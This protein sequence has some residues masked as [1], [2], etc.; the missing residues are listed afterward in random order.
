M[1]S[2]GELL[3]VAESVGARQRHSVEPRRLPCVIGV[4]SGLGGNAFE[5][6]LSRRDPR[7]YAR[8]PVAAHLVPHGHGA[9]IPA[10]RPVQR[11]LQVLGGR[12]HEGGG[13]RERPSSRASPFERSA[14]Q[15]QLDRR[16]LSAGAGRGGHRQSVRVAERARVA[17]VGEREAHLGAVHGLHGRARLPGEHRLRLPD[18][19]VCGGRGSSRRQW[20]RRRR[21]PR[22]HD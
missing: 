3:T 4:D 18:V 7:G 10:E 22:G 8:S 16:R 12:G 6:Q 9:R 21:Y 17:P 5:E 2:D 19:R 14:R 1:H 13:A 20:D 15:C 11:R